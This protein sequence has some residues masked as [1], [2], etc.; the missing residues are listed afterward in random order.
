[1]K[2]G[3][4]ALQGDFLAH[5]LIV[6]A[7][8]FAVVEVRTS[9]DLATVDALVIP[10]GESTT[11]RILASRSGLLPELRARAEAGM[12]ILGTCAGLIACAA[13]IVEDEQPILGHVDISV[14]RN[15]YGRQNESFETDLTVEGIGDVRAIFIRAPQIVRVGD[16]VEVLASFN[17]IPVVVRQ[18]KT[19]LVAFHPEINGESRVHEAWINALS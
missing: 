11:I 4:L 17:D 7:L 16:G 10:G 12:P 3:V 14:R 19:L 2:I 13:E 15:A 1:V 9:S 8:G 18:G 5:A 6:R